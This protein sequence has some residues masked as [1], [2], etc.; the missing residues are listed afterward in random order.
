[1]KFDTECYLGFYLIVMC[2]IGS[3]NFLSVMLYWQLARVRYMVSY[4]VQGAWARFDNKIKNSI[5][6][7][8]RC[9]GMVRS[10]YYKVRG[11]M[12]SMIPDPQAEAAR[13]QAGGG[14]IMRAM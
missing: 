14:G 5:L 6:G 9:P 1:M 2:L 3:G 4:G 12:A 10:V 11:F 8:P 13:Q 7:H